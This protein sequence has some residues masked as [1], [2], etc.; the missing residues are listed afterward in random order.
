[1]LVRIALALGCVLIALGAA[2][3]ARRQAARYRA[4]HYVRF[5]PTEP[6]VMTAMLSFAAIRPDDVVYDLGCGDGRL[7]I[8]AILAGANRGVC[9]DLDPIRI[10]A[11]EALAARAGVMGKIRFVVGDVRTTPFDDATVVFLYLSPDLNRELAPRLHRLPAGSR[12]V[13]HWHDMG[14]WTP[15][16]GQ[17]VYCDRFGLRPV[18]LWTI[19]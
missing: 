16:L 13:S 17:L 18:Y 12:I 19:K 5:V 10:M 3:H 4:R 7:V 15:D 9:V 6:G 11:A 1:M 8:R 2:L 14:E